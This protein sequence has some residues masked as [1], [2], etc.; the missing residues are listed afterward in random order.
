[1]PKTLKITTGETPLIILAV[2]AYLAAFGLVMIL[3][4]IYLVPLLLVLPV[5]GYY[6]FQSLIKPILIL[7][8]MMGATI[9]GNV[10]TIIPDGTVPFTLFQIFLLL[11][12]VVFL[13]H[14]LIFNRGRFRILG[15]ELELLLILTLIS[16]SII[17]SPNRESA[18]LNLTRILFLIVMVYLIVNML[19]ERAHF[20]YIF[21][22]L[23]VISVIL[24]LFSL[25]ATLLDPVMAVLNIQ[26]GGTVIFG[27]GAITVHDPN[28]FATLFFLPIACTTSVFLSR[29]HLYWKIPALFVTLVLLAGLAST[30]SRSA[31]I[32]TAFLLLMLVIYYRQYKL[33]I[34]TFITVLVI[35][36]S[37][38]ELRSMSVGIFNRLLDIFSGVAD[39]SSRIRVLLG[40]AAVRMFFDSYMLGVG[41]RGYPEKFT[42]YF[43]TQE[44]IG[45]VESHNVIYEILAELG[46][47]GFILFVMLAVIIFR[48]ASQNIRLSITSFDKIIATSLITSLTAYLIFFQFYGGALVSTNIWALI[49]LILAHKYYLQD[50][51]HHKKAPIA[52]AESR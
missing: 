7:V 5:A 44:T 48:Y 52:E 11:G 12:V 22:L 27:R 14:Y 26:A 38:P 4:F 41:F 46:I 15:I 34:F 18:V 6:M 31:W 23:I 16:F 28:I 21:G 25:R 9:L 13:F 47:P 45:V 2:L 40:I 49:G 39:D 35:I 36:L 19:K 1:V 29:L 17:Y 51:P 30:Y 24:G 3:G 37:I 42:N 32:S 33:M 10:V 50:H 43:N 8:P 20:G